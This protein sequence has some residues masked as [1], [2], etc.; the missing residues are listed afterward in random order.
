MKTLKTIAA[1]AAIATASIAAPVQ[2]HDGTIG[3]IIEFAGEFCPR[4]TLPADGR[5]LTVDAYPALYQILGNRF[6]GDDEPG[7]GLPMTFALPKFT[8]TRFG[9][10]VFEGTFKCIVVGGYYPSRP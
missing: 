7:R 8:V 4:N 9:E 6:G 5:I 2:A 1:T 3:E 10:E